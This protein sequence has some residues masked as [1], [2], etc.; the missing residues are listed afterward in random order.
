MIVIEFLKTIIPSIAPGVLQVSGGGIITPALQVITDQLGNPS[1]LQL[2]NSLVNITSRLVLGGITTAF[3]AIKRNGAAIDF[4]LADDSAFCGINVGTIG[5]GI[6]NSTIPFQVKTTT[7]NTNG[8]II[9]SNT[10]GA[11]IAAITDSGSA[12]TYLQ[13]RA[14]NYNFADAEQGVL[15][16]GIYGQIADASSSLEIK[17]TLRG[18]LPPK[19]TTIEKNAIRSPAEGLFM[20]DN[21]LKKMCFFNGNFYETITSE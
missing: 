3:P 13:F 21:M 18:F 2:S 10:T 15:I 20:Y 19:L 6:A 17:G 12:L 16:G 5:V 4:K 11:T 14:S 9:F 1:T 7:Q 8:S